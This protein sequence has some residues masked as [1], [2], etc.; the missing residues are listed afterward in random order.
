MRVGVVFGGRSV[1]HQVSV[2]TGLQIMENL[3]ASRYT[4]VPIYIDQEGKWFT[5]EVLKDFATYR[6]GD[7]SQ[8]IQV[9]VNPTKGDHSL[10]AIPD[11]VKLFGKK[12]VDTIDV[13]FPALHGTYGE[14]GKMQGILEW[15]NIP[16][17]GCGVLAASVGMDKILMKDVFKANEIPVV[18]YVWF[19]RKAWEN[20]HR[21]V[22]ADIEERLPYP[23]FVKPA[24][25]GSSVGISK[26]HNQ[27]ELKN[28][29]E[30]ARAFDRKIIVE[31]AVDNPREINC[32]VL[33]IDDR[34][35][36]SLCEEPVTAGE[37]LTFEDKYF[38]KAKGS[39]TGEKIVPQ[40]GESTSNRRIPAELPED[41]QNK[42]ERLAKAAFMVIDGAGTARIDFLLDEENTV[43][44]NEINTLPGSLG[45]YLWEGKGIDFQALTHECIE[46]ALE[47][48]RET[49]ENMST[50]DV[51][52]YENTGF[53]AKS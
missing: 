10:Y 52:L 8:A 15:M 36:A 44:V 22:I 9:M 48:H 16:Y 42:I 1:E 14:D 32:A 11:Q 45:Y 17:V 46:M 5:G 31:Q 20:N 49:D 26:A 47:R 35:E 19:Y 51:N 18:P 43:Y 34:V 23:V 29:I 4:A 30:V 28:S 38:K 33:G 25:L 13:V 12:V 50:F 41:I 7:F 53:G 6:S 39:K 27:E 21:K 24:N 37:L 3:D 40:K 2:I